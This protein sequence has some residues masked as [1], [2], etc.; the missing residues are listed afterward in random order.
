LDFTVIARASFRLY[1]RYI[2]LFLPPAILFQFAHPLATILNWNLDTTQPVFVIFK[3]QLLIWYSC[4]VTFIISREL[5]IQ[6]YKKYTGWS[7]MFLKFM[8]V[9]ILTLIMTM[10]YILVEYS[11][12]FDTLS[13][14]FLVFTLPL[15]NS[16]AI[17]DP[18]PFG[19]CWKPMVILTSNWYTLHKWMY[20]AIFIFLISI[21]EVFV[22]PYMWGVL[23]ACLYPISPIISTV[24]LVRTKQRYDLSK[25][26]RK[27][28]R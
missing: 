28:T 7:D 22:K 6:D 5:V 1:F 15:M 26:N 4:Y 18:S 11:A 23:T 10:R 3:Y 9:Y 24:F 12:T 16:Y 27:N 19:F 25:I 13:Y 8:A 2:W 14:S 20:F 21:F 17:L